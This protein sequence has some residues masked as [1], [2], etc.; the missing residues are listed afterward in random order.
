MFV[1]DPPETVSPVNVA[2]VASNVPVKAAP[3]P[4][5]IVPFRIALTIFVIFGTI[6]VSPMV[7]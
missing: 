7:R 3:G 2:L 6:N 1:S 5:V 4:A